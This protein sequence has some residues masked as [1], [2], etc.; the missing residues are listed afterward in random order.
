MCL[1]LP[2]AYSLSIK[3]GIQL[4]DAG[5]NL[6]AKE[7]HGSNPEINTD[8][9]LRRP[10]S[11]HSVP[12]MLDWRLKIGPQHSGS[13]P[14]S[15]CST[16]E[17]WRQVWSQLEKMIIKKRWEKQRKTNKR[18]GILKNHVFFLHFTQNRFLVG[19]NTQLLPGSEQT[20]TCLQ[21]KT[22]LES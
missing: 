5:M 16:T 12:G 6:Y 9:A 2:V 21:S 19:F 20:C 1:L 14:Q 7:K 3:L 17:L 11:L 18:E 8:H 22:Q 10:C 4:E 13:H 15:K